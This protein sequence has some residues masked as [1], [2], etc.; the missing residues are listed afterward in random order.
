KFSN[1][2]CHFDYRESGFKKKYKDQFIISSVTF[3]LDKKHRFHIS[4][5]AIEQELKRIGVTEIS[6]RAISDAVIRIR[7]SK[8]PDPAIIGNAGS[9]FKNPEI[10]SWQFDD[11]KNKYPEIVGY[12][13][14]GGKV[15]LAAGWLI[16]KAGWKGFR[17]GD[18]GCHEN[19]AL[20]LVNYGHA[21][22]G[23]I[24]NLSEKILKDIFEKFGIMLEREV[25]IY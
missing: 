3:R 8:L 9:F 2:D 21:K 12:P 18:A 23:D 6:I 25:N 5:G 19:Q 14:V 4:Y 17:E 13:L 1:A 22:G 24:F 10:S 7:T 15:K 20:V 11:L 16:E